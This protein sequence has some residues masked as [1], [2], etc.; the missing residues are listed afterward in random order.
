MPKLK[1]KHQAFQSSTLEI[2]ACVRISD[3]YLKG[4]KAFMEEYEVEKAIVVWTE[5]LERLHKG[6]ILR[7]QVFLQKL[8]NG[9]LMS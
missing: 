1:T 3:R 4:L 8:W 9:E 2:K 7:W 6:I 5:P